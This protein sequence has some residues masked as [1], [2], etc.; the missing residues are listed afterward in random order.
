[1]ENQTLLDIVDTLVSKTPV[2]GWTPF[3]RLKKVSDMN[4]GEIEKEICV[5]GGKHLIVNW[6]NWVNRS[7]GK[8]PSQNC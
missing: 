1:M 8:A 3:E 6:D 5:R 2:R 7:K 4:P